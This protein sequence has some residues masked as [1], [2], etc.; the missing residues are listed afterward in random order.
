MCRGETRFL[1]LTILTFLE[2]SLCRQAG[3][4]LTHLM[5]LSSAG[6]EGGAPPPQ[7]FM[8]SRLAWSSHIFIIF[9]VLSVHMN[10]G[11]HRGQRCLIPV[12]RHWNYMEL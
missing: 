1:C 3:L 10:T 12:P 9:I 8:Y 6:I 5:H 2:L 7:D 11:A 4:E